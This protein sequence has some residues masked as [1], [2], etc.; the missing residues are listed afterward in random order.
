MDF[1]LFFLLSSLCVKHIPFYIISNKYLFEIMPKK[2][3]KF[4]FKSIGWPWE[5]QITRDSLTERWSS[6]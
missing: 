1:F 3:S 5:G 4:I 6:K 2:E